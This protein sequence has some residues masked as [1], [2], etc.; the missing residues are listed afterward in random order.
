MYCVWIKLMFK[1]VSTFTFDYDWEICEYEP[2]A[3]VVIIGYRCVGILN[4]DAIYALWLH[5]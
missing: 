5:W 1:T 3:N 2:A 4:Y